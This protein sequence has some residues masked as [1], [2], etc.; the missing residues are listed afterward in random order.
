[1]KMATVKILLIS[2]LLTGG[3]VDVSLSQSPEAKQSSDCLDQTIQAKDGKTEKVE[4]DKGYLKGYITDTK[5]ILTSPLRWQR[6][7]WMKASLIAGITLGLYACDENT[8]DWVQENRNDTSDDIAKFAKIFGDGK[9]TLPPLAGLFLYGHFSENSKARR[10]ALLSLES[11]VVSGFFTLSIKFAGHRHRPGEAD[12]PYVWDGP[13]LYREN[14]SFP[15]GHAQS[16]FS[17]ATVISSEY[18]D[19]EVIPPLAYGLATLT[20]LSRVNDNAHWSSDVFFSSA[21]SYFTAKAIIR[22]HKKD[23]GNNLI[24]LPLIDSKYTGL[25]LSYQF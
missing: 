10:V 24:V 1:M 4:L 22:R 12:S 11:Y 7:D 13:G 5:S 14:Q 2:V 6:A 15:S 18:S 21:L 20:A 25:L 8:Q 3:F 17:I 19:I 16:A 23:K 9:Y